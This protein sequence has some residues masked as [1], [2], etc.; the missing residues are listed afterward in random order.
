VEKLVYLDAADLAER[1]FPPRPEPPSDESLF[2]SA[3]FKSLWNY[4]AATARFNALR[5]PDPAVCIGVQF[6][7]NGALIGSTTPDW[8]NDKLSAAVEG[9]VNP[10][11]HW[12]NIDAPRLGIFALF[13]IEARTPW[14]WYLTSAEQAV[15]DEVWPPMLPGT[16]IPSGSSLTE[17][18]FILLYCPELH[19]MFIS[20]MR[21]KSFGRCGSS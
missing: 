9:S 18:Q 15:F 11:T 4:Q 14:Y 12:A 10:P 2:T 21:P 19:T 13:T 20:I 16:E 5:K 3:T 17:T 1:F 8:V 7:A 6:D